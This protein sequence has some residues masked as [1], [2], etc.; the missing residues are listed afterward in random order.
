MLG[1][2]AFFTYNC[3]THCGQFNHDGRWADLEDGELS[4]RDRFARWAL[5]ADEHRSVAP[6]GWGPSEQASCS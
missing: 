2:R 6:R 1:A 3:A 5:S 4:L